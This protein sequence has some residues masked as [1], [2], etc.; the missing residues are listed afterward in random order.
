MIYYC[1]R[2]CLRIDDQLERRRETKAAT[3]VCVYS[4]VFKSQ[5]TERP[6]FNIWTS[7][8]CESRTGPGDELDFC[9]LSTSRSSFS[10]THQTWWLKHFWNGT[11]RRRLVDWKRLLVARCVTKEASFCCNWKHRKFG[12]SSFFPL[13]SAPSVSQ[14]AHKTHKH[15]QT[16]SKWQ[17]MSVWGSREGD[18]VS[19]SL[20]SPC[21]F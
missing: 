6:S 12:A 14:L 9:F 20:C 15:S 4:S 3:D 5:Q 10:K 7:S 21:L 17:R 16:F 11:R 18:I 2:F 19:I 13:A 1:S 8:G